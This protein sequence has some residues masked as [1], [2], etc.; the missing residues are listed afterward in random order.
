MKTEELPFPHGE[1]LVAAT[2]HPEALF[3]PFLDGFTN[4]KV[5][6][7]T[8]HAKF[9]PNKSTNGLVLYAFVVVMMHTMTK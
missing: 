5:L 2:F 8:L 9:H 3:Q 7:H 1:H 4:Y 6:S